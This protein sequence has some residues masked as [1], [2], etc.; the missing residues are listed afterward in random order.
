MSLV[1]G[2]VRQKLLHTSVDDFDDGVG[3]PLTELGSRFLDSVVGGTNWLLV[4]IFWK[5]L[6]VLH[7]GI[8]MHE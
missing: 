7:A 4:S 3:D 2:V 1:M 8:E 5:D 6:K